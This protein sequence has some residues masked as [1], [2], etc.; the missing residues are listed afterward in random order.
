ML[1][2]R[3]YPVIRMNPDEAGSD[4]GI[5]KHSS[6]QSLAVATLTYYPT[7]SC[8]DWLTDTAKY[9]PPA[10]SASSSTG[11]AMPKKVE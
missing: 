7:P 8:L 5:V 9:L 10:G 6:R 3:R 4:A 11:G 2:R 1:T